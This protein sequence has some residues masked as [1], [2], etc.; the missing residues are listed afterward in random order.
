[1]LNIAIGKLYHKVPSHLAHTQISAR[2]YTVWQ[3]QYSDPNT[4][5]PGMIN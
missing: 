5:R 2:R 4:D 3:Q 1:M